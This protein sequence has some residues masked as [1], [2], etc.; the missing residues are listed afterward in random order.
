VPLAQVLQGPV[1]AS[2]QQT[3]S[4]PEEQM[5]VAQSAPPLAGAHPRPVLPSHVPAALQARPGGQVP[6]DPTERRP[7]RPPPQLAH[8][9]AQAAGQQTWSPPEQKP[10]SHCAPLAHA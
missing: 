9:P 8:G 7:Q 10:L 3:L 5:P 1:H 6:R 2:L 4:T